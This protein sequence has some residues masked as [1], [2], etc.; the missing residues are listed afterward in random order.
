MC[1]LSR[2]KQSFFRYR[3]R[4]GNERF[5]ECNNVCLSPPPLFVIF[6]NLATCQ[7]PLNWIE[8]RIENCLKNCQPVW[9]G[10]SFMLSATDGKV[11]LLLLPLLQ[12]AGKLFLMRTAEEPTHFT[13]LTISY[14]L[15]PFVSSSS[16]AFFTFAI[17]VLF[18][19]S[20]FFNT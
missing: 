14:E 17:Q 6:G 8:L 5:S 11:L 10:F 2:N 20:F 12:Y 4:V 3:K 19:F 15:L 9:T 18:L 16:G 1:L 7:N 13:Q